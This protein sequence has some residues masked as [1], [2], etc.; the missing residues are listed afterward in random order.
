MQVGSAA[1]QFA[2]DVQGLQDLK[3]G[4]REQSPE[5]LRAAAQQFEALF[6][7]SMIKG[8]RATVPTSDLTN[9]KQTEF[10]QSLLDHQW[11][12]TMAERGIGLADQLV[13]QLEAGYRP[14][15]GDDGQPARAASASRGDEADLIAGIPRGVP[16]LLETPIRPQGSSTADAAS[17]AAAA[18]SKADQGGDKDNETRQM[19]NS[20]SSLPAADAAASDGVLA[21]GNLG[22]LV[23]EGSADS[24]LAAWA[25]HS[26]GRLVD[27]AEGSSTG[28][29]IDA[30]S[31]ES[32]GLLESWQGATGGLL[33]GWATPAASADQVTL[34]DPDSAQAEH[35][36]TF[37]SQL[38]APAQAASQRTGVPAELILAQA[39]LETGWGRH[40]IVTADGRN[41]HNLFGIK[42]GSRW[43]GPTTAITTHEY[44]DGQ[45]ARVRD[46]FRV[47]ESYEAAFTDYGRLISGQPRY[48]AVGTAPSA[49]QA[50][51]ELQAG[52]YATDPAY[53]DKLIK[54][55]GR[56]GPAVAD[57]RG[58]P[59]PLI[60]GF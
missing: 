48:A 42:A 14:P 45:R 19:A 29:L 57:V 38:A 47:Y 24:F 46:S 55:M 6:L 56:F 52:G 31:Q 9:S 16:R 3:R 13:E 41:S 35:I 21:A 44:I 10:Y 4:A 22:K 12:Q 59:G 8:M 30:W 53:A 1:S 18:A 49:E 20:G 15:P 26:G 51:R 40:Q 7:H 32:G 11:A 33:D 60:E 5:A 37:L 23:G 28:A 2:L 54:I 17:T 25:G 36:Q 43:Q 58:A 27:R 34:A 39:A 50:A